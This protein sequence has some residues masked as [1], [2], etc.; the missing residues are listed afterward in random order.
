M[1]CNCGKKQSLVQGATSFVLTMPD[2]GQS[3]HPTRLEAEVQN[4][5][6]GGGG[7]VKRAG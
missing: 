2:G 7:R 1:G 4:I 3:Q 5:R 6:S